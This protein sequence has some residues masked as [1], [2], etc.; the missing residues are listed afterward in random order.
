LTRL[1]SSVNSPQLTTDHRQLTTVSVRQTTLILLIVAIAAVVQS[2]AQE[3]IPPRRLDPSSK[4]AAVQALLNAENNKDKEPMLGDVDPIAKPDFSYSDAEPNTIVPEGRPPEAIELFHC[5][6]G[7]AWDAN[8]DTWPDRWSREQSVDF[9]HYLKIG[10]VEEPAAND[11]T[12]DAPSTSPQRS[13]KVELN[14][15]AAAVHTPPIEV[16]AM[17]T[18]VVEGRVRTEGLKHDEARL[19]LTF[20]DANNKPLE[21]IS[22][23]PIRRTTGWTKVRIGPIASTSQH[24]E[25]ALVTLYLSPTDKVDLKGSA[26]FSD[27]WLGRLPRMTLT[28]DHRSH[29]YLDDETPQITCSASGFAEQHTKVIFEL[30]DVHDKVVATSDVRLVAQ[31]D[32]RSSNSTWQ[33]GGDKDA[34]AIPSTAPDK[35]TPSET[36]GASAPPADD[37]PNRSAAPIFAGTAVWEPQ[38]PKPGFYRVR[39]EMPGKTG[40]ANRREIS[41]ALARRLSPPSGGEFGWSLPTGEQ[42]LTLTQLAEVMGHSGCN[43]CKFPLWDESHPTDREEQLVWFAERLGLRRIEL[44]GLLSSPP[45]VLQKQLFGAESQQAAGI[46]S[47]PTQMWYPSLEPI[48]TR[49][50]LKVRWWQLGLDRD[51]S[52]VGYPELGKKIEQLK[53]QFTRY[54][55]RVHLGMGWSW[56]KELPGEKPTW[57]FLAFSADPALT[58][59]EQITYL[60]ATKDRGCLRWVVLDP[61]RREHYSLETRIADLAMR[62]IAAKME[63]A[64][65]IFVPE[66]FSDSHGILNQDGTVGELFIPWRTAAHILA[67]AKPLGTLQLP[68]NCRT[69]VFQR[70][71]EIVM[72]VWSDQPTRVPLFLGEDARQIDLWG[73]ETPVPM[74]DGVQVVEVGP[75]PVF[76]TQISAAL[77]RTQM[78]VQFENTKLAS[79]FGQPQYNAVKFKSFFP[80]S[81][82]G[83]VRIVTPGTW[84]VA[85]KDIAFKTAPGETMFQQFEVALPTDATTGRQLLRLDFDLTADRR[86]QFSIYRQLEVGL[87]DVFGEAFTRLNE[88]GELEVEQRITN[89]TDEVLSFKCYLYAPDRKRLMLQVEDHGRGVDVKMFKVYNGETLLNKTLY[90]RA[91]EINGPRIL[92]YTVVAQP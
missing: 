41:L 72:A 78:S 34:P 19:A 42:D 61:L 68:S 29:L 89:E 17:Y 24:V 36:T 46:F 59:E 27:I 71:E 25:S 6:F 55:Q 92:N 73:S 37:G 16:D 75:K 83:Q 38:L 31:Q 81:I 90:L 21:T 20:L 12:T 39:V 60:R 54:G 57:D 35:S 8:F 85:P 52:F 5:D 3:R 33:D 45:D 58:W 22:S 9:P 86:Y 15:G 50:S 53:K 26:W 76:I 4:A 77:M 10:I 49:M 62:M 82:R 43:W 88:N 13:L 79:L 70:G 51:Q 2:D 64:E 44:V 1:S 48:M 66:A 65:G 23:E 28:A 30:V 69:Q 47:M 56:L 32:A 84:K 74:E 11:A 18:Y 80:Q 40:V 14:G 63:G 67:G 87:S 7:P 91:V